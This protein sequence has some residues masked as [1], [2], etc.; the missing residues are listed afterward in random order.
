M[1]THLT[2]GRLQNWFQYQKKKFQMIFTKFLRADDTLTLARNLL[3]RQPYVYHGYD[4]PQ[5]RI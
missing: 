2:E 4:R 1:V 5:N 3:F